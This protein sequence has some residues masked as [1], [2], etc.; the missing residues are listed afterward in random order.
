MLIVGGVINRAILDLRRDVVRYRVEQG[1][2]SARGRHRGKDGA[3]ATHDFTIEA[4][5]APARMGLRTLML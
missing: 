4:A 3:E 5:L 1:N 2:R